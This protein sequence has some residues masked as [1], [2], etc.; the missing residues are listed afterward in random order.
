MLRGLKI[1]LVLFLSIISI[2]LSAQF[3]LDFFRDTTQSLNVSVNGGF[4]YGSTV[5]DN[6]FSNKFLFGGK[7]EREDKDRAYEKLSA[8]PFYNRLGLDFGFNVS[9]EIPF[10]TLF[11][12]T[13]FSLIL[14]VDY[15]DHFDASFEDDLFRF[16]FDGN[17]QFAGDSIFLRRTNFNQYKLHYLNVG[18]VHYNKGKKKSRIGGVLSFVHGQQMQ[19]IQADNSSFKMDDL[20]RQVDLSLTYKYH[21]S[22]TST[23]AMFPFSGIGVSSKVFATYYFDDKD[24]FEF[25]I[26]NLGVVFW[27]N[28]TQYLATNNG[29]YSYDGLYVENIFDINDSVIDNLS[30]DSIVNAIS[31]GNNKEQF[32]MFLPASVHVKYTKVLNQKWVVDFGAYHRIRANYFPYIFSNVYHY[33]NPSFSAKFQLAYG[34][35]GRFNYGLA[36]AKSIKNSF[37]VYIGTYN[38]EGFLLPSNAY[39]NSGFIGLKKYF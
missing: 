13:D 23:N 16:V 2:N 27:N 11:G 38:L 1:K 32:N 33:F 3:N 6:T 20:G 8:D 34:G 10:D 9:A 29:E 21:S 12:R 17:K 39:S 22:D 28:K 15:L 18:L 30:K 25:T 36:I 19:M 4:I 5:M 35:Y 14:G 31:D 24:I 37:H 26:E 7:I